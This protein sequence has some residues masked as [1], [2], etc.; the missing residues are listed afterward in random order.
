MSKEEKRLQSNLQVLIDWFERNRNNSTH[1]IKCNVDTDFCISFY[2]QT[3]TSKHFLC[4]R[5]EFQLKLVEMLE[6]I[7]LTQQNTFCNMIRHNDKTSKILNYYGLTLESTCFV[8][9]G[10]EDGIFESY[11]QTEEGSFEELEAVS[12]K[13]HAKIRRLQAVSTK[14]ELDLWLI[15]F[16][17]KYLYMV[18]KFKYSVIKNRNAMMALEMASAILFDFPSERYQRLFSFLKNSNVKLLKRKM[19]EILKR[20]AS[21]MNAAK[22]ASFVRRLTL[23]IH[24]VEMIKV[25]KCIMSHATQTLKIYFE[26]Q[27]HN[28]YGDYWIETQRNQTLNQYCSMMCHNPDYV[29]WEKH[30]FVIRICTADDLKH[31]VENI[32]L[33]IKLCGTEKEYW[34]ALKLAR[35]SFQLANG[36]MKHKMVA[37]IRNQKY[38]FKRKLRKIKCII[39]GNVRIRKICS[40]CMKVNYCS[41]KC[42]KC[43]WNNDHRN[44][45]NRLWN[46]LYHVLKISLFDRL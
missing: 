39:C 41:K 32:N 19:T 45:C 20:M 6:S 7:S 8:F 17:Y 29:K 5:N 25:G 4:E 11:V 12:A 33:L 36:Y 16:V 37:K 9:A 23:D 40:G 30:Y 46:Q 13:Q 43:H 14:Q 42:Q 22:F 31:R 38:H 15:I 3:L 24:Y 34:M 18:R 10:T 2:P 26:S 27:K 1:T 35:M 21:H 44:S 28:K